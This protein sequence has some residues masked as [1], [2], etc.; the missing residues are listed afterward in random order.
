MGGPALP[1]R[2][3]S[4]PRAWERER[5]SKAGPWPSCL[6][7][8]MGKQGAEGVFPAP[9][10][11]WTSSTMGSPSELLSR[12]PAASSPWPAVSFSAL[13]MER[14][15]TWNAYSGFGVCRAEG[16]VR[17]SSGQQ[18]TA[19]ACGTWDLACGRGWKPGGGGRL[20]GEPPNSPRRQS[21]ILV[22]DE[23]P[24]P[25]VLAPPPVA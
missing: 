16:T 6:Q 11:L 3:F 14:Q 23:P 7:P 12:S 9:A 22:G 24:C 17:A 2:G 8:G 25:R 18:G 4:Q 1:G 19:W 20:E 5:N 10:H 21:D 15:D 13:E